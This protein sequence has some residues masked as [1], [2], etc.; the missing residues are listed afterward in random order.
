MSWVV[1]RDKDK[2]GVAIQNY[3]GEDEMCLNLSVGDPVHV[4]E[5]CG[6]DWA[7]GYITH[8]LDMKGIFPR[9]YIQSKECKVDKSGPVERVIPKLPPVIQELTAALREW[10]M[11]LRHSFR[12]GR[13]NFKPA[14]DD[15]L[16][17]INLRKKILSGKVPLDELKRLK[18]KVTQK[19]DLVNRLLG[20]DLVVRDDH[21]N[22][23]NT[24]I[25]STTKLFRTHTKTDALL[26]TAQRGAEGSS[27]SRR[28]P[29]LSWTAHI[30]FTNIILKVPCQCEVSVAI[31]GVDP[32]TSRTRALTEAYVFPWTPQGY[33]LENDL[34]QKLQC[35]YTDL[36]TGLLTSTRLWLVGVVVQEGRPQHAVA[37]R[38]MSTSSLMP[39]RKVG[40]K[41]SSNTIPLDNLRRPHGVFA[42]DMTEMLVRQKRVFSPSAPVTLNTTQP[43]EGRARFT[44]CGEKECLEA[45]IRRLIM[46][47]S[48][49]KTSDE[50]V[51]FNITLHNGDINMLRQEHPHYLPFKEVP[52]APRLDLAEVIV[53]G[54]VRNDLYVTLLGAEVSRGSKMSDRNVEVTVRAYDNNNKQL[55]GV[56]SAGVGKENLQEYR[57]V[58]YHH[59]NR[60]RWLETVKVAIPIN[61]FKGAHLRFTFRHRSMNEVKEKN[62]RII[63]LAFVNLMQSNGTTLNNEEHELYLYNVE[64]KKWNGEDCQYLELPWLRGASFSE[65]VS[66]QSCN[67]LTLAA[68][69]AFTIAT[70]F[71]STKLTQNVNLLKLLE[72]SGRLSN[73][74]GTELL[75]SGGGG[76]HMTNG[77]ADHSAG[78]GQGSPSEGSL[79]EELVECLSQL[80]VVPREELV[81]FLQDTLDVL[82]HLLI[83]APDTNNLDNAVFE[84]LVDVVYIAGE[85]H[86]GE[87]VQPVL[88]SYID[89]NFS[90]AMVYNKL[91]VL[92]KDY[93]D[94]GSR[95]TSCRRSLRTVGDRTVSATSLERVTGELFPLNRMDDNISLPDGVS[96]A[97]DNLSTN[98]ELLS[99]SSDSSI[100][101]L[102]KV[103]NK[104]LKC[105]PYLIKFI[106][107][108]RQ[109]CA[110]YYVQGHEEFCKSLEG[111][112]QSLARLMGNDADVVLSAQGQCLKYISAIIPDVI[113]V[114]NPVTFSKLLVQLLENL[115]PGQLTPQKLTTIDQIC[116]S[117][118]FVDAQCREI[119]L[120]S[121]VRQLKV[122][123][124]SS[125]EIAHSG[126]ARMGERSVN[127]AKKLLG[128]DSSQVALDKALASQKTQETNRFIEVSKVVEILEDILDVLHSE[129]G[130]PTTTENMKY[131]TD[132]LLQQILVLAYKTPYKG[133]SSDPCSDREPIAARYMC[134]LMGLVRQV[135]EDHLFRF[136][137]ANSDVLV[138]ELVIAIRNFVE[139][140]VFKKDWAQM[141]L[142]LNNILLTL[143]RVCAN[144]ISDK[145]REPF[146][147]DNWN[148][149]FQCTVK[150]ITQ[151]GLQLEKFLPSKRSKIRLLYQDMRKIAAEQVKK[152]WNGLGQHKLA[153]IVRAGNFCLVAAMLEMTLIP[154]PELRRSTIPIFF[155]MMQCEYYSAK[156]QPS[157]APPVMG[158]K[159]QPIK[160]KFYDFETE[161]LVRL[162]QYVGSG[163]GDDHYCNV[164][165]SILGDLVKQHV[166]LREPGKKFVQTITSQLKRLLQYRSIFDS[167]GHSTETRMCCIVHLL[168]FYSEFSNKELF[169]R[170]VNKLVN[171]H[172][173]SNNLTEAGFAL[174]E[175]A[176]ILLWEHVKLP[177]ALVSPRYT[178]ILYHDQ[179]REQLYND[180]IKNME[181]GNM[182]ECAMERCKELVDHY[183][184]RVMDYNKLS[185]LHT[186][187]SRCYQSIMNPNAV[188]PEPEYFRVAYYGRGFPGFLQNK[189]FVHRGNG[190]ER[191]SEFQSRLLDQFPNAELLTKLT[192]PEQDKQESPEQYIQI[193]KVECVVEPSKFTE[194]GVAE[195]IR[196][197]YRVNH[198]RQFHYSRPF[199]RGDRVKDNEF[200]TLCVEK[201]TLHIQYSLPGILRCFP[202]E[203]QETVE[204]SPLQHAIETMRTSNIELRDLVQSHSLRFDLPLDSL[205]RKISGMVD[206]A[207]MG[208]VANYEKAFLQDDY[209]AAHPEEETE[210]E[211]LISLIKDMVP[212]LELGLVV[213]SERVP[214][215]I[216][217]LHDHMIVQ[218]GKMKETLA[219]KYGNAVF[220]NLNIIRRSLRPLRQTSMDGSIGRNSQYGIANE[221][222]T[223]LNRLSMGSSS[224]L[225]RKGLSSSSL[226]A[227]TKTKNS[228]IFARLR[229]ESSSFIEKGQQTQSLFYDQHASLQL[230]T[231]QQPIFEITETLMTE[232][233]PRCESSDHR[234][235]R[236]S[237]LVSL[238]TTASSTPPPTPT[239]STGGSIESLCTT[240]AEKECRSTES[241]A[242]PPLPAKTKSMLDP[243]RSSFRPKSGALQNSSDGL[244][245][246]ALPPE[247]PPR[248]VVYLSTS[249]N[250]NNNIHNGN[251]K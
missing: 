177:Q 221:S 98:G 27:S 216:T 31:H 121:F 180:I 82:L 122:L 58:T 159:E 165:S 88:N 196:R 9:A 80:R 169:V 13:E 226:T 201:T 150:F 205:T 35:M 241:E 138:P 86:K 187:M 195:A 67:G 64:T 247:K 218:F 11:L 96:I 244:D 240:T 243:D 235:S 125:L 103:L 92:L 117:E 207:V 181:E 3:H 7:Y 211:E 115:S 47:A 242:P 208:G 164:F 184:N 239:H 91:I 120:K 236:P 57:T 153:F 111:L 199:H 212:L 225:P 44:L 78:G 6:M 146:Q 245:N 161:M 116:H 25:T 26:A 84:A 46:Q 246:N 224:T 15:I 131:I 230:T 186:R 232:R 190:F 251:L 102:N 123:L 81:T 154:E 238:N 19:I 1:S 72:W 217:N 178:N 109:L 179:L 167:S 51:V 204:L 21:G 95:M 99:F 54:Y 144:V 198:I 71:C 227:S 2:Y 215:Q 41:P 62:P 182:W 162:D 202:V 24:N 222:Q 147:K 14:Y 16:E 75:S 73:S 157:G 223:S 50:S 85:Q 173:K 185:Q 56:L 248:P 166:T 33:T 112:F 152:M 174:H 100:V 139:N 36:S 237:S 105:L 206:A 74:C 113:T 104:T 168:D 191:L 155:D 158:P 151:P 194:P 233:P 172:I 231:Q 61:Q 176:K 183:E 45:S 193:N 134:V 197:F 145:M 53:P 107:K 93:V 10:R 38:R 101:E 160:D 214:A 30:H 12:D 60:P 52:V 87:A 18:Q 234:N 55:M 137:S 77:G 163:Y 32:E 175:H 83:K 43:E 250:N 76:G 90:A 126:M 156:L 149:W 66:K 203:N 97:I 40:T 49:S 135:P 114:F 108:S 5:V 4:L 209:R 192:P 22:I 133:L 210:I 119:L 69:D 79:A 189:I 17:L 140:P 200:A 170:Y 229:R 8:N 42:L 142:L 220:P 110:K 219:F 118:L 65:A 143:L 63:A 136:L 132:E 106:V 130:N 148:N 68:K 128:E 249:N 228:K 59:E 127:K 188:R 28:K 70:T 34:Y 29:H 23:L 94:R 141:T 39:S 213:H 37:D 129:Q 171:L 48:D 89:N 20:L 124:D